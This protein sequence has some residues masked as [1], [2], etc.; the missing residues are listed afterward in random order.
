MCEEQ[1]KQTSSIPNLILFFHLHFQMN[2]SGYPNFSPSMSRTL[3]EK[4]MIMIVSLSYL[5]SWSS[6]RQRASFPV[7]VC[8]GF[9]LFFF[10]FSL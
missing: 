10:N 8:V 1:L 3:E 9:F 5:L 2:S 4:L 7:H 6:L